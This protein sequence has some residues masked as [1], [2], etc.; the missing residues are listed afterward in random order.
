MKIY[1]IGIP[2]D[3]RMVDSIELFTDG[4]KAGRRA[5]KLATLGFPNGYVYRPEVFVFE[6]KVPRKRVCAS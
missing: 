1:A 6:L 2:W 5:D 4:N 3:S